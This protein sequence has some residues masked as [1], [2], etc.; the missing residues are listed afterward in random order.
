MIGVEH[1]GACLLLV[2]ALFARFLGDR[3][4]LPAEP[5]APEVT[6]AL[7]DNADNARAVC[8]WL[9]ETFNGDLLPLSGDIFD[10]LPAKAYHV[11]GNI[12]VRAPGGQLFLG[13]A[14][15]WDRLAFAHIPVGT[16]KSGV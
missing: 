14:E 11:L 8:S 7:F 10:R 2:R 1:G 5:D 13:W 16:R 4:L 3:Y 6:A 12:M 9:D 15:R